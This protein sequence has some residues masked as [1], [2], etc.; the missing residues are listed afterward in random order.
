[1]A[2]MNLSF[3]NSTS[4]S[5]EVQKF[6][7]RSGVTDNSFERHMKYSRNYRLNSCNFC[8]SCNFLYLRKLNYE[9]ERKNQ[10]QREFQSP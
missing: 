5:S 4:R 10:L 1:M 7:L 6:P 2:F 3:A 8:N 9:S